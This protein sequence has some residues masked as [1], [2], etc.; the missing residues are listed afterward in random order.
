MLGL[1]KILDLQNHYSQLEI[2]KKELD[3]L[4]DNQELSKL[5][6][7]YISDKMNLEKVLIAYKENEKEIKDN[8]RELEDYGVKFKKT[9]TTIY[10]GEITDLNQLE[11]LNKE[12]TYLSGLMDSLENKIIDTLEK[13]E[14]LEIKIKEWQDEIINKE[15]MIKDLENGTKKSISNLNKEIERDTNYIDK[16]TE[17]IDTELLRQFLAIKEKKNVGIAKIVDGACSEC[18]IMIRPAQIDRIKLGKQIYT[19]ESCG[20]ILYYVGAKND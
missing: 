17:E 12:K 4:E 20:I 5:E 1:E 10:N 9:E 19:C 15:K 3:K 7:I 2:S 14:N 6:R 11:H 8:T 16:C 18:N 13:N